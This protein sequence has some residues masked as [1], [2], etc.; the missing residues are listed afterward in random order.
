MR[1]SCR[2][3]VGISQRMQKNCLPAS[4]AKWER[5]RLSL[6][7]A[8]G[9]AYEVFQA[10]DVSNAKIAAFTP[11]HA[12]GAEPAQLARDRFAMRAD[13]IGDIGERRGWGE[14]ALSG[15]IPGV[16]CETEQLGMNSI[17]HN[18][19]AELHNPL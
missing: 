17:L 12:N 19:G 15:A 1:L 18:E 4:M 16:G 10:C 7:F 14:Q 2:W 9:L 8:L 6:L 11:Q 3:V 13:L 5:C